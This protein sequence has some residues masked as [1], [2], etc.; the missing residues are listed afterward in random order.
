MFMQASYLS[1]MQTHSLQ[2]PHCW[3]CCTH[4]TPP[5]LHNCC[6]AGEK[7]MKSQVELGSGVYCRALVPDTSHIFISIGLGFHLEVSLDEAGRVIDLKQE[8]LRG[9]VERCIDKAARIKANLKFVSEAIR[10][11]TDWPGI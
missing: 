4:T 8:A 7:K 5:C 1:P 6:Q 10:E 3:L 9:H 11:L 2:S